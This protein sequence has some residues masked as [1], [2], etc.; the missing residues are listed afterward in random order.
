M[1]P[2]NSEATSSQQLVDKS[3][4]LSFLRSFQWTPAIH[5]DGDVDNV[6]VFLFRRQRHEVRAE[7]L[8]ALP[9]FRPRPLLRHQFVARLELLSVLE[10]CMTNGG[11]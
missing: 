11:H 10:P 2:Y 7:T 6:V 3:A 1:T 5:L 9:C 8:T 4:S